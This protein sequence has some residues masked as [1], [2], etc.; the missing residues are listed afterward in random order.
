MKA[1]EI[2]T[3]TRNEIK[4]KSICFVLD[5]LLALSF[6]PRYNLLDQNRIYFA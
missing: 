6:P 4:L 3:A 5:M 2:V 1:S